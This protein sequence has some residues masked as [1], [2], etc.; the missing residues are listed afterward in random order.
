MRLSL[1]LALVV[2]T[3]GCGGAAAATDST[4][5]APAGDAEQSDQGFTDYAASHGIQTLNGGGGDAPEATADGLRLESVD[6]DKP[7]KLDGV[8]LEWPPFAKATVAL[9]GVS[10]S[11]ML[12]G[13]QYDDAKLYVAAEIK[14]AS[15]AVGRDHVSLVLAVPTPSSTYETYDLAIFAGKPGESE[16]SVRF[17][18]R[19]AVAGAKIVEA[20]DAGGYTLEAAIPW[21]SLPAARTT[22]VGI[23]GVARY[24]EG[25]A[26]IATGPLDVQHPASMAWIPSEPELSMIEQF[27]APKGLTKTTPSF[28]AVADLTGDG[29]RERIA[30]F[31][32]FLTICG[33]AYLGGTGFFYRD[34]GGDLVRLDV[35][36]ATG[37]GKGD[38]VIRRRATVGSSTRETLEV[39]SAMSNTDEPR[40]TFAHEIEVRQSDKHID[41][42]VRLS[43][44]EI[45][46]TV[47]PST[48]WDAL[49][50]KEPIASDTASIL[51][52]WGAVRSETWRWD[53]SHFK[54]ASEVT[55]R[56][57]MPGSGTVG[58]TVDR[59]PARPEEPPTP[60]VARGGSLSESMLDQYRK[61]RGAGDAAPKNDLR[62]QVAGDARPERV[63]LIGRDI[64]VFGP[65]F[66]GGTG[67]SFVTL[68]QFAGAADVTELSARDLT[69]DGAADLI[70]RGVRHVTSDGGSVDSEVLFVYQVTG[71]AIT[72]VFGIETARE[73]AN[74]RVQGLVQF[75]PAPGN[76]TF[77]VLAAPGRAVGWTEKT[78][79][80][81]QDQ[82]G[83][84]DL[85]PLILP[86]G[87]IHDVRYRWNG[88]GFAKL[89]D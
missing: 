69:G 67:Y 87:G 77:D 18:G 74:K 61:D 21:S 81:A 46:V 9:R 35:R 83:S 30:V 79:P 13:L 39:L 6:K 68:A 4:A 54:K 49:S 64:V 53:G 57:Q 78:Y 20:P 12:I 84:G 8:P 37:R 14:D 17:G 71:D 88:S 40:V 19:G 31:D 26:E 56:E 15:F 42:A 52:P 45:D 50:Y 10:K 3:A 76:K 60:K 44:G 27:L 80:W 34:L 65:G 32:H 75:I 36:D 25:D 7:I 48:T 23:H 22:R 28:D 1:P 47:E 2:L 11:Q 86:W 24:V 29:I 70:V 58:G 38:V 85:E 41:N 82:P 89:G 63:V 59:G 55:Q 43:R 72:R 66:K 51:F 33:S 62:V 73:R 5:K 16:G